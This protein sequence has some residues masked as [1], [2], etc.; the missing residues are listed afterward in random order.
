M[1]RAQPLGRAQQHP[2]VLEVFRALGERNLRATLSKA[3]S[4]GQAQQPGTDT[5]SSGDVQSQGKGMAW[6]TLWMTRNNCFPV[7]KG[8]SQ[9]MMGWA[10]C[11]PN[12]AAWEPPTCSP[13]AW[14]QTTPALGQGQAH[15]TRGF[16]EM[17]PL[18][19]S[20]PERRIQQERQGNGIFRHPAWD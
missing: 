8:D 5:R 11:E 3:M 4:S 17:L 12:P 20:L 9:G 14:G 1:G 15:P 16:G 7:N 2:R 19:T 10:S 18:Q 13:P 6:K